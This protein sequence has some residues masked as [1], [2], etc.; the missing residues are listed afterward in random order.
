[1]GIIYNLM[2]LN[3]KI[4]VLLEHSRIVLIMNVQ[5]VILIVKLVS[6][7]ENLNVM[8]VILDFF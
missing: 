1:M 5:L 3:V 8:V 2:I 6:E 7:Q 4:L